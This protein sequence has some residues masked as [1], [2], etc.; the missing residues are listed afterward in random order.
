MASLE[1]QERS[2]QI[3]I[4]RD[5]VSRATAGRRIEHLE[6]RFQEILSQLHT[7]EIGPLEQSFI[8]RITYLPV[9]QGRRFDNLSSLGLKVLVNVAH[10]LAHHEAGIELGI[11][12]PGILIIDGPSSNIG[13]EGE[14]LA[15]I[16]SIYQKLIETGERFG[17]E[18]Q[19]IVADNN[20]LNYASP[21]VRVHLTEEDRLI[22]SVDLE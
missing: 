21:F 4:G 16:E 3:E 12:I 1:E 18:L 6:N 17:D 5:E 19:I 13:H 9:I 10:A 22:P 7:P 8:D 15:R 20:V 11:P 14:D 2:L